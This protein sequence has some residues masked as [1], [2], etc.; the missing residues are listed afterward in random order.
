[1]T[2][3]QE[4][5]FDVSRETD[6]PDRRTDEE[7]Y[8]AAMSRGAL[9]TKCP[10]YGK[11]QG[12]VM[13]PIKRGPLTVL[14]ESPSPAEIKLGEPMIGQSGLVLNEALLKGNLHRENVTIL[15]TICC[16]PEED[17]QEYHAR[18]IIE[19]EIA[20]KAA[21]VRGDDPETWP[22]KPMTPEECCFPRLQRDMREAQEAGT[23]TVAVVGGTALRAVAKV[24]EIPYGGQAKVK[25]GEVKIVSLTKSIGMAI[26]KPGC[27]VLIPTYHP[28]FAMRPGSRQY[29]PIVSTHLAAA[30]KCAVAG[31]VTGWTMPEEMIIFPE[32]DVIEAKLEE[33]TVN[34]IVDGRTVYCD[35]E[36]DGIQT[37]R[38]N[39]RCIQFAQHLP[40]GRWSVICVPIR[41]IDGTEWWPNFDQKRRVIQAVARILNDPDVP[42]TGHNFNVFDTA[43]LIAKKLIKD[44]KRPYGCTLL[45]TKNSWTGDLP[46]NLGFLSARFRTPPAWKNDA[47]DKYVENVTDRVL[48]EYGCLDAVETGRNDEELDREH[49]IYGT[50]SQ[51]QTDLA[52]APHF[53]NMTDIGLLSDMKK[54]AELWFE[55][56]DRR[57]H[58]FLRLQRA[59]RVASRGEVKLEHPEQIDEWVQYGPIDTFNPNATGDIRDFL[60]RLKKIT[61][62]IATKKGKPWQEGDDP[63][64]NTVALTR[65][66]S[67]RSVDNETREFIN[68]LQEYRAYDKLV[69]TYLAGLVKP[70][71][72]TACPVCDATLDRC[73]GGTCSVCGSPVGYTTI[74]HHKVEG[75]G[76]GLW[77]LIHPVWKQHIATGRVSAAPACH[78]A[79]TEILTTRGWVMFP[80]LREDDLVA[81]YDW[82]T[83]A[84]SFVKPSRIVSYEHKGELLE[85]ISERYAFK[86]TADH[87]FSTLNTDS[88]R[89]T[90]TAGDWFKDRAVCAP[91]DFTLA[92]TQPYDDRVWCVTVP[93]DMIVTRYQGRPCIAHNCM[94]WPS[95][96]KIN[97]RELII[98]PPDYVIVGMDLDQVELR[99]Y[100]A[101]AEDEKLWEAFRRGLDPHAWNYASMRA[102]NPFNDAEVMKIYEVVHNL[103]K[104]GA[105]GTG[106]DEDLKKGKD[107]KKHYRTIAKRMVYL[108]TYGGE[109]EKLYATMVADRD[110]ATGKLLF[111][112]LKE[113]DTKRWYDNWHKAHPETVRWQRICQKAAEV[114]GYVSSPMLD[115]RRRWFR[116]GLDKKNA[117]ANAVIQSSSAAIMNRGMLRVANAIGHREW[118]PMAGLIL[119]VHDYLGAYIPKRRAME[120]VNLF[121]ELVPYEWRGM[122]FTAKAEACKVWDGKAI[123]EEILASWAA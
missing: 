112:D 45:K 29:K 90:R 94:N 2:I 121:D 70:R 27:P 109:A 97:M 89:R 28:A 76:D 60:Y 123:P 120:A 41:H 40:D 13:R 62:V 96:G 55:M 68:A 52:L 74:E 7:V 54:H 35:I 56:S 116:G 48:H 36:T 15:N 47:S 58:H 25:A 79:D 75:M 8:A 72:V 93:N 38:C 119:Q 53:R 5:D 30:V 18:I 117:P 63:S 31:G 113:G 57:A 98:P 14:A 24:Y 91:Y 92:K 16:R 46:L 21:K 49:I 107:L 83:Q 71:G 6:Q 9:C 61:P 108:I 100:C 110:K 87:R 114:H 20:V 22:A 69:G 85:V 64:V 99:L 78:S 1:M 51:Y 82:G 101:I 118:G 50:K 42:M 115:Y 105:T 19:W 33:Y 32:P 77:P 73:Y 122:K 106:T 84:I 12:P 81:Q 26:I 104:R 34:A 103:D 86:V 88:P 3:V 10:L 11:H 4:R 66:L 65:I 59:V 44:L 43:V 102:N 67:E 111:P 80:Q 39:V 17:Y 37:R 95:V 23:N